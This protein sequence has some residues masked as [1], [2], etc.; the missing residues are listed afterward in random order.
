MNA[1]AIVTYMKTTAALFNLSEFGFLAWPRVKILNP[2]TSVFGSVKTVTIPNTGVL[3]GMC[4]RTDNARPGG[5]YEAPAGLPYGRMPVVV[6]L[7]V[8]KEVI[9]D[10]V[11]PA[12]INPITDGGNGLVLD[13]TRLLKSNGNFKNIAAR[14]GVSF[15]EK[16]SRLGSDFARHR[17]NTSELR[18]QVDRVIRQ[19]LLSQ[20]RVGAFKT[21]DPAT[22]FFVDV[23]DGL[24]TPDVIASGQILVRIGL[25][26]NDTVDWVILTFTKDTREYDQQLAVL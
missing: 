13:G 12:N 4:A 11:Y 20:M 14:R 25:N 17:N 6:G 19:F 26:T 16:S 9:R 5:I 22:A 3:A 10:Y 7:Q 1:Q 15:I 24:N 23:G 18:A 21:K 8:L 2:N